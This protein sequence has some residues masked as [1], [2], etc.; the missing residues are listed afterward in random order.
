MFTNTIGSRILGLIAGMAILASCATSPEADHT[1]EDRQRREPITRVTATETTRPAEIK[2][3]KKPRRTVYRIKF[4]DTTDFDDQLGNRL[5]EKYT[6]VVVRPVAPF[7]VNK[8]PERLDKWLYAVKQRGGKVELDELPPETLL[9]R[10][11]VFSFVID[12]IVRAFEL[13]RERV[14]YDSAKDYDVIISYR[15]DTGRVEHLTF[16]RRT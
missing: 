5:D 12:F 14:K 4:I 7:S 16:L 9:A 2:P 8:I 3:P 6:Q 1:L 11:S 10:R 13:M 15:S